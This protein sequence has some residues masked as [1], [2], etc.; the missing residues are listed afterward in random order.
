MSPAPDERLV[1]VSSLAMDQASILLLEEWLQDC[2]NRE[3]GLIAWLF[4]AAHSIAKTDGVCRLE[5]DC[6]T[7]V[8]WMGVI[9]FWRRSGRVLVLL[10]IYR[11][12]VW[13]GQTKGA[14]R[15]RAGKDAKRERRIREDKR[16]GL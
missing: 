8:T 11:A 12:S 6:T 2:P 4:A 3:H 9:W 1:K 15:K 10:D 13:T 16:G 5:D 7:R 14:R